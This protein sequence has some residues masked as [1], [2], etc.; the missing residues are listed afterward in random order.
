MP[1][2]KLDAGGTAE[3]AE[4]LQFI[5]EWLARDPARLGASLEEFAGHPAYG[6]AQLRADPERFVFCPG[7]RR[8]AALRPMTAI[9][10]QPSLTTRAGFPCRAHSASSRS[11]VLAMLSVWTLPL[12][13]PARSLFRRS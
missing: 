9:R 4:T 3:L 13:I 8:R 2:A 5:S 6:L 1:E 7:Q 11:S 10:G 12:S